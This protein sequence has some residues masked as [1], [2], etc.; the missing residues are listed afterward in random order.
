MPTPGGASKEDNHLHQ[1][2]ED[3]LMAMSDLQRQQALLMT[4]LQREREE[5]GD[6]QRAFEALLKCLRLPS[7]STDGNE[8][9]K[10]ER[11][12]TLPEILIPAVSSNGSTNSPTNPDFK[13]ALAS[14]TARVAQYQASLNAPPESPSS[15]HYETKQRLRDS[16]IRS[17]T[18]LST[19][20][21]RSAALGQ[22]LDKAEHETSQIRE[23]LRQTQARLQEVIVERN[24]IEN[25]YQETQRPRA[26]RA[27][28]TAWSEVSTPLESQ[29]PSFWRT[30]TMENHSSSTSGT[31]SNSISSI[32]SNI[33]TTSSNTKGLRELKL[34]ASITPRP[35][36]PSNIPPRRIAS[37]TM[38][39]ILSTPDHAPAKEE[40]ML[41]ELV[42]AKT[43]EAVA[44]QEL[45]ECKV[46]LEQLRRMHSLPSTPGVA[47]S[48]L[49]SPNYVLDK[50]MPIVHKPTPSDGTLAAMM[51]PAVGGLMPQ[52]SPVRPASPARTPTQA[53]VSS[54][55]GGWGWGWGRRTASVSVEKDK[56]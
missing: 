48:A 11:R 33:T 55:S 34:S 39:R 3:L 22:Q 38:Q 21:S 42:N 15:G 35:S 8:S 13:T 6:D 30:D 1:Q 16:L 49:A 12:Q 29:R 31:R 40:E 4:Q 56:A 37:L 25:K 44:R 54:G 20:V 26:A 43:A 51:P 46:Q 24:R 53:S 2:I 47:T 14:A 10:E 7:L 36:T 18:Q 27:D 19:E 9:T 50:Q 52:V 23:T 45:E 41:V 17:R 5:R 32:T 28:S